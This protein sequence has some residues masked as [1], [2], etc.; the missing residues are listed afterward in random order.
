MPKGTNIFSK[1]SWGKK[2]IKSEFNME[3]IKSN[4]SSTE[5]SKI[6]LV[7]DLSE[8]GFGQLAKV[9]LALDVYFSGINTVGYQAY[10]LHL[11]TIWEEHALA[12]E[13]NSAQSEFV[14]AKRLFN[15]LKLECPE[16]G[17]IGKNQAL[18][19]LYLHSLDLLDHI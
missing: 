19:A 4:Y 13:A 1:N 14:T 17:I 15:K 2:Q 11:K 18:K 6:V 10:I 8:I 16:G 5:F 7:H 12:L 9:I 3:L